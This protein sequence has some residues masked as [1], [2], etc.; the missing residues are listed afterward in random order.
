MNIYQSHTYRKDLSWLYFGDEQVK[1]QQTYIPIFVA[2]QYI[3]V[4]GRCISLGMITVLHGRLHGRFIEMSNLMKKKFL[5][6]IRVLI[7]LEP[8][9]TAET[10]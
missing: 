10:V 1:D 2:F 9:L 8:V 7:F 5:E 6:R 4:P 3:Q